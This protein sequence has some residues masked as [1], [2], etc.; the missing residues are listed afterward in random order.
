MDI[1]GPAG[2]NP[3]RIFNFRNGCMHAMELFCYEAKVP[4]LEL[5]TWSQQHLGYL[6]LD[7]VLFD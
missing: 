1:F 3:G 7:T 2:Q 6:P 4:N 5:K